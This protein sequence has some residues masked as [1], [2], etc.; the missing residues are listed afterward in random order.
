MDLQ[1]VTQAIRGAT[2]ESLVVFDEFGKGT[3]DADGIAI[4]CAVC[5]EFMHR[6]A[7]CPT[8]LVST[9]FHD[10]SRRKLLPCNPFTEY[11]IMQTLV[12]DDGNLVRV[13]MELFR[14]LVSKSL[15]SGG[16]PDLLVSNSRRNCN[17]IVRQIYSFSCWITGFPFRSRRS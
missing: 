4:L 1:Q 6:E 12:N 9:H 16:S 10:I 14:L 7:A 15:T 3:L 5:E 2:A 8:L 17:H 13:E 11:K